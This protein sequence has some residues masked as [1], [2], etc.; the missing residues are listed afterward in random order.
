[1]AA[2]GVHTNAC[3]PVLSSFLWLLL[4]GHSSP[5]CHARGVIRPCEPVEMWECSIV[6]VVA[7]AFVLASAFATFSFAPFCFAAAALALRRMRE[8]RL[9]G[10]C[11]GGMPQETELAPMCSVVWAWVAAAISCAIRPAEVLT[12]KLPGPP[13]WEAAFHWCCQRCCL[14][15]PRICCCGRRG[16]CGCLLL[17]L[18]EC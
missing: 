17:M 9:R 14:L 4:L 5:G 1:M 6:L 7:H 11:V 12:L 3:M 10:A 8:V 2:E 15:P 18:L 16:C 13:V